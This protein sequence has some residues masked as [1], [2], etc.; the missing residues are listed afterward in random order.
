[1]L[2]REVTLRRRTGYV[3]ITGFLAACLGA[4]GPAT[5]RGPSQPDYEV[6]HESGL[7]VPLPDGIR[8]WAEVYRPDAPGNFPALLLFRYFGEGARQAK[9]FAPRGYVVALIGCRGRLGSE[10]K[11]VPYVN[12]P[13]DGY[14]AQQW[15][16]QQAWCNGKIGTFGIS[17]NG[18]TQLMSAPYASGYLKCLFPTEGQQ[19]NFGHLYNDGVMQLNVVFEFGLHTIQGSQTQRIF[20][21]RHPHYRKLPLIRAV[22]DFRLLARCLV[23]IVTGAH[24]VAFVLD[25]FGVRWVFGFPIR[26]GGLLLGLVEVEVCN[27]NLEQRRFI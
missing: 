27:C 19:T 15:L 13:Q 24:L 2:R 4:A 1:M 8:L 25:A 22:D 21:S 16:G 11:W 26:F 12:D 14:H 5:A 23:W 9:F 6:I 20:D 17:Y 18:F 10:G 7:M 3:A